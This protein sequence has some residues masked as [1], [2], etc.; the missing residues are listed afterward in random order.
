MS[1]FL[2]PH[3][4]HW[5]PGL[6]RH[7]TL[8]KTHLFY[9]AQVAATRYP[10]KPFVV[11]YDTP[12]TF[13]EFRHDAE[14]IAGWLQREAHVQP[15]DRVLLDMQNS[16]QWLLAYYGILR[17]DAVVVPINPM[18]RTEELRHYVTD[19]GASVAFVA[20]DLLP[21][22]QPLLGQFGSDA[23]GL[24]RIVVATYSDWLRAP[25][26][27]AVPAFVA[28]PAIALECEGL[29]A[30]RD[31]I[32]ASLKP[33][34]MCAGPEDLA[35]M[36]YTSGTTGQPKGCMHTHAS[37]MCT[38]VTSAQ[39]LGRTQDAVAL[40][41][42]PLFHV[43]GM[44]GGMNSL[45]FVGATNVL[46][47][48]WDRDAAA[49]CI[50]RYRITTWQTTTTMVIDFLANP[51]L[52]EYD[53]SSLVSIRGGGA[54]MP[55]A[56][57]E[58]LKLIT[59][60][61]FIEGYGMT[62]TMAGGTVNPPHRPKPQCLGIPT[63]DVDA[64]VVDPVTLSEL[65]QGEA[66]EIVLHGPHLMQ[67]YWR[68]PDATRAAFI[69]LDGKRFLHTGDLGRVDGDGYL[70]MTDRLKRMIN[71]AGYK[72]WPAEV[73]ALMYRHPAIEEVCV[74]GALDARRGETV[75]ALIVL[76]SE[77]RGRVTVR[78]IIDWAHAHMAIYKIPR[79][80]EFVDALPKS[81]S[82][83]LMWRALQDRQ[84]ALDRSAQDA[85]TFGSSLGPLCHGGSEATPIRRTGAIS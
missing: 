85:G 80:V 83:K 41:V 30:W 49:Q 42:L 39:W 43:T 75:K 51:N 8:P 32:Q 72:V 79:L 10:D 82:G 71:A 31:V 25:S 33:G 38:A 76:R 36:P 28:A 17:A 29:I 26:D 54:A 56:V 63:F 23:L 7:L 24:R 60:L 77:H 47:P 4:A 44:V 12:L 11:F 15:G 65:P 55:P 34:P 58:K 74:I 16:P 18:N 46:L 67:G 50:A 64:R 1:N 27:M 45:L 66:G 3:F 52:G 69:E 2:E 20:Q 61:D 70:F 59:G 9:N 5:P 19:T 53:L 57:S 13:A 14:R 40:S 22:I 81:G 73:E 48:R 35:V 37:V 84:A 78:E 6:P 68:Q 62:E 21:E